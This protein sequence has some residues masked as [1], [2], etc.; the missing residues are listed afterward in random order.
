MLLHCR[1]RCV[2]FNFFFFLKS[3][4]P[5]TNESFLLNLILCPPVFRSILALR[6]LQAV[7]PSW[8]KMERSQ[9]MKFLVE[10][11]FNFLG[12]LLSTCSSDLPL[13][14]GTFLFRVG[15]IQ[16]MNMFPITK[17]HLNQYS[18]NR[19]FP[20]KEEVPSSGLSNSHSQQHTGR[21]NCSGVAHFTFSQPVEQPHK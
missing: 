13:L 2:I 19:G 11:L 16:R 20:S 4:M 18:P 5:Q 17:K 7:L 8:D 14:R 12:S 15:H 6:L 1:D 10:K 9:D 3:L 21:G